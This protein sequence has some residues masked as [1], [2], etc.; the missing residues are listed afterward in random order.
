MARPMSYRKANKRAQALR[1]SK[2][3]TDPVNGGLWIIL[4]AK[5]RSTHQ[6]RMDGRVVMAPVLGYHI[7][8]LVFGRGFEPH[9]IQ[10]LGASVLPILE[11]I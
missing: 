1:R 8:T 9:S 11:S 7:R 3:S 5:G 2:S 6:K 10:N 4:C